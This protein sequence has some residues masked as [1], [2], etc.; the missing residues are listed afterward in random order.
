MPNHIEQKFTDRLKLYCASILI[1]LRAASHRFT[2]GY[3]SICA[4]GAKSKWHWASVA[5]ALQRLRILEVN[6]RTGF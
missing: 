1:G 2:P 4:S 3:C 5:A 6:S